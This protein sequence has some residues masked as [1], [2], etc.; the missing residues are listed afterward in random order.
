MFSS[1]YIKVNEN[2]IDL[3]KNYLI[4]KH[5]NFSDIQL[6]ELNRGHFI[7]RFKLSLAISVT[8]STL[9]L[10]WGLSSLEFI[11]SGMLPNFYNRGGILLHIIIPWL[12]FLASSIWIYQSLRKCTVIEIHSNNRKDRVPLIEFEKD[13]SINDLIR[14]LSNKTELKILKN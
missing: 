4:D 8:M 5:I 12:I 2:G 1:Q 3:M 14:F 11:G 9:T 10:L 6:I 7:K 13:K